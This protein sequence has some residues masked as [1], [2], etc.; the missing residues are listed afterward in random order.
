M[1]TATGDRT[2]IYDELQKLNDKARN[3]SDGMRELEKK[4]EEEADELR[5]DLKTH[6]KVDRR[7]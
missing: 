7:R 3:Q 6:E 4:L 2:H 1:K 5:A